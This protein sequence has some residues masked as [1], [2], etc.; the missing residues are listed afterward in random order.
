MDSSSSPGCR[1]DSTF[2]RAIATFS[3]DLGTPRIQGW[4]DW[5]GM[6]IPEAVAAADIVV[7]VGIPSVVLA[8]E[9]APPGTEPLVDQAL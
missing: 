5:D 1:V 9:R 7:E 2:A 4:I 8:E 3:Q 6:R